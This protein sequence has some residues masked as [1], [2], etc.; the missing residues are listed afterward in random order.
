[1]QNGTLG[2]ARVRAFLANRFW[3]LERS[4]DVQGADFLIQINSLANSVLDNA[5]PRFGVVQAKFV[6]SGSTTIRIPASYLKRDDGTLSKEF[7]LIVCT[8]YD[9]DDRMYLLD[10]KTI[11]DSFDTRVTKKRKKIVRTLRASEIL[12]STNHEIT[13]TRRHALRKMQSA[14][15]R[16]NYQSNKSWLHSIGYGQQPTPTLDHRYEYPVT[17][18]AGNLPGML[19]GWK[20]RAEN[21]LV[22]L[23]DVASSLHAG[24]NASTPDEL[25]AVLDDLDD[26]TEKIN[27]SEHFFRI[28]A[29][30]DME[31]FFGGSD[32]LDRLIAAL[33]STGIEGSWLA[34]AERG[35]SLTAMALA[36]PID[37]RKA[38]LSFT[39][40]YDPKTLALQSFHYQH[41]TVA[42]S[43]DW[44]HVYPQ[45]S[46]GHVRVFIDAENAY[47][48]PQ[49]PTYLSVLTFILGREILPDVLKVTELN[50]I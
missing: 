34:L 36:D 45:N 38:G 9:D 10:T 50:D 5:P 14:L 15:M 8:G 17:N 11:D 37:R 41:E 24:L 43:G 2:E 26:F 22:E 44:Y 13:T 27:S 28:R 47:R 46:P 33:E 31:D 12:N 6:Q 16:A 25:R 29:P 40:D 35:Q 7:F 4:I 3:V 20:K 42:P 23:G 19:S 18:W 32:Q 21:A 49:R 1:M 48:T 39:V 30:S